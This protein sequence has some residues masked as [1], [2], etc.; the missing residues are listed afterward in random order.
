MPFPNVETQFKPGQSGNPTGEGAGRP[1]KKLYAE[2]FAMNLKDLP[3]AEKMGLVEKYGNVP[4][5]KAMGMQ[6]LAKFF[7]GEKFVDIHKEAHD[8]AEGTAVK[9]LEITG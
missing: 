1:S 6:M 2:L 7:E 3:F 8:R 4:V 5:H 9:A